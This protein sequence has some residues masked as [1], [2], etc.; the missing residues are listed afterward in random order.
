MYPARFDY[1]RPN[2]LEAA[3]ELLEQ[4]GAQV[5]AGGHSLLPA[6]KRRK[7][8]VASLVD[9]STLSELHGV[10]LDHDDGVITIGASMTYTEL[11]AS[12]IVR[13]HL[14]MLV[15]ALEQ[16]GDHQI[17]NRGTIGGNL[18]QADLG[19]DL[20]AVG[21]AQD[22]K[23]LLC[24][25]EGTRTLAIADLYATEEGLSARGTPAPNALA[26]AEM[27]TAVQVPIRDAGG[28]Y[29]RKTHPATGY[30][31]IGIAARVRTSPAGMIDDIRLAA[32]GLTRWPIRL[33]SAEGVL[34]NGSINDITLTRASQAV[35]S[36]LEDTPITHDANVSSAYRRSIAGRY[37]ISTIERA[38]E[39]SEGVDR[40]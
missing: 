1:H 27:I 11:L 35:R 17:R 9:V 21:L 26:N 8:E 32:T 23:L 36:Q 38:V 29:H 22:A 13:A 19:A 14:P 25:P 28:A 4:E 3:L 34:N 16:L 39:R 30:A 7:T 6:L 31:L 2:S 5:L 10:S 18:V 37:T 24:G 33:R 15:D 20:P 12:D 40:V